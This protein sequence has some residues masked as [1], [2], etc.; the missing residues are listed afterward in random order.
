VVEARW[1]R[2]PLSNAVS[3]GNLQLANL[4]RSSGGVM[5][6]SSG[7]MDIC[8]SAAIGDV[9]TMKLLVECA[10]VKVTLPGPAL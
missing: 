4:L 10:G 5:L 9:K 3:Q 7:V 8:K 2:T 6:E 1:Q